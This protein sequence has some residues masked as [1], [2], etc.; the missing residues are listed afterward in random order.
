[1]LGIA[2]AFNY[3]GTIDV[4]AGATYS[5]VARSLHPVLGFFAGWSLVVSA[6]IFMV[7]G[8]LLAGAYTL[9]LFSDTAANNTWATIGVGALV[10]LM[11]AA[12]VLRGVTITAQ[13][14]GPGVSGCTS[15]MP[16]GRARISCT[17]ELPDE[18][19]PAEHWTAGA[20]W[21][22]SPC[23]VWQVADRQVSTVLHG[24]GPIHHGRGHTVVVATTQLQ[25]VTSQAVPSLS[26]S[27]SLLTRYTAGFT[28]GRKWPV[29]TW[30]FAALTERATPCFQTRCIAAQLG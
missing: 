30:K 24:P 19:S 10:F 16:C 27:L 7:A 13:T 23:R 28:A 26:A 2:L 4:H 29:R 14:R 22:R 5:W 6:T 11:M 8:S 9:S 20:G 17:G 18:S 3:L 15:T 1:M 25:L 21:R 12:L